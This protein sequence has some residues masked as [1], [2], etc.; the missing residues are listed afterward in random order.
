MERFLRFLLYA[1]LFTPLLVF[2]SLFFPYITSKMLALEGLILIAALIWLYLWQKNHERYAPKITSL[3]LGIGGY[4]VIQFIAALQGANF[5]RSFYSTYERMDGI[6]IW[7]S[8]FLLFFVLSALYKKREDWLWLF[9]ISLA[10]SIIIGFKAVDLFG[11]LNGTLN[12]PTHISAVFNS[13]IYLGIYALFHVGIALVLLRSLD[14]Q[15]RTFKDFFPFVKSIESVFYSFGLVVNGLVVFLT[16]SRGVMLGTFAG[17]VIFILWYLLWGKER[18]ILVKTV[19]VALTFL[20][21]SFPL[22]KDSEFAARA[23]SITKG[24]SADPTRVIN[25]QVGFDAFKAR[26]LLGWGPYNYLTAQNESYNPH[27][28]YLINQAF[29]KVHNKYI[30]IAVD[31]G[32]M[33]IA[34]YAGI[35]LLIFFSIWRA[36][37]KE[38]FLTALF[39]G[40]FTGYLVQNIT[41]FDNPGS[42]L[43]LFLFLAFINSEFFEQ[44]KFQLKPNSLLIVGGWLLVAALAWQ[45]VWQPYRANVALANTL[46]KQQAKEKDL[47]GILEGYK[48]A[49]SYQSMGDYEIRI[50]LGTFIIN[51]QE[52]TRQLLDTAISELEKESETSRQDVLIHIILAKLYE[53]KGVALKDNSF[54]EKAER[55]LVRAIELSPAR[56]DSYHYYAAFLINQGRSEDAQRAMEKIRKLD[57]D[58]FESKKTQWY[59]GMSYFMEG[60]FQK[61]YDQF[62]TLIS[63]GKLSGTP[64]ELLILARTAAELKKYKEMVKWYEDLYRIDTEN[65]QYNIFLALAYKEV[66]N[67]VHAEEFAKRAVRLNP[68]LTAEVQK[69]LQSLK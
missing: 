63:Q 13:P 59:I 6:F 45:G 35:F 16:F 10:I 31:T 65:P 55:A 20:V 44:L 17:V 27:L 26:P 24:A 46:V 8:L 37:R 49:L 57:K 34:S 22:W 68:E 15:F 11:A 2:K 4:I 23:F 60:N 40:V 64:E 51:E 12:V 5:W 42:Y 62:Q 67:L 58:I 56:G 41:A 47:Q 39:A 53:R 3:T 7:I 28:Q 48:N 69:F 14:R 9:R 18:A 50:Q 38:P 54:F 33:G 30:E 52:L 66:G 43:P 32:I 1:T 19:G 61:A 21:I 25:W 29:D 36:R